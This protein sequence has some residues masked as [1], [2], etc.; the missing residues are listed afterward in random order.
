MC[1]DVFTEISTEEMVSSCHALH[2]LHVFHPHCDQHE[3]NKLITNLVQLPRNMLLK[4]AENSQKLLPTLLL[5]TL[6]ILLDT[7]V[8]FKSHVGT[9]ADSSSQVGVHRD[10]LR[11]KT[12]SVLYNREFSPDMTLPIAS[13]HHLLS[14]LQSSPCVQLDTAV[15][16]ILKSSSEYIS[17]C[18]LSLLDYCLDNP[19]EIRVVIA[20]TLISHSITMR[21]HLETRCLVAVGGAN[22]SD[23]EVQQCS[24]KALSFEDNLQEFVPLVWAYLES[25]Q[26]QGNNTAGTSWVLCK[27]IHFIFQLGL[28]YK[29]FLENLAEFIERTLWSVGSY[30]LIPDTNQN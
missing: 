26:Q 7:K 23:K 12:S 6:L 25:V 29:L 19:T 18:P 20:A 2:L 21:V 1:I 30:V 17:A 3:L 27:Q 22:T 24:V 4:P 5:E 11:D 9:K 28:I 16:N 13:F 14:L 8:S 10:V 15:C